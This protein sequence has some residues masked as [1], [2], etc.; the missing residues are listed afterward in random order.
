MAKAL[1]GYQHGDRTCPP[2][3]L[4]LNCF[5]PQTYSNL[6]G[7]PYRY[8][9]ELEKQKAEQVFGSSLLPDNQIPGVYT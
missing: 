9:W 1:Q 7:T 2:S 8:I 5:P 3:H 6:G 4:H